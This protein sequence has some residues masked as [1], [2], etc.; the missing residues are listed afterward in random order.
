MIISQKYNPL[1][2][3]KSEKLLNKFIDRLIK[4]RL[5]EEQKMAEN[6]CLHSKVIRK[7]VQEHFADILVDCGLLELFFTGGEV[8]TRSDFEELYVYAKKKGLIV[9]VLSNISLLNEKHIKLFKKYPVAQISTTMYG[10]SEKTYRRVTGIKGG[11]EKFRHGLFL[12][13]E[14]NIPFELYSF[15]F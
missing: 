10:V 2:E 8:F 11:Y 14:N 4:M 9:S 15:A 13:K 5:I 6:F 3:S 12:L 1:N 7:F